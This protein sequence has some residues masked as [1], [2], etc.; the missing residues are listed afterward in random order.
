MTTAYHPQANG[1][2][3]WGHRQLQDSLCSWAAGVDWLA[4]LSWVL[5]GLR[6]AP[7]D[8]SGFSSAELVLGSPLTLPG[9]F[10]SSPEPLAAN[11]MQRIQRAPFP[12]PMC[13]LTYAEA[14]APPWQPSR[15]Q[16]LSTSAAAAPFKCYRHCTVA[17]TR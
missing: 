16:T 3:E 11:F 8:E 5:L 6:A 2:V 15:R 10:L 17:P 12:P 4:H 9:Q 1:M 13:P 7:K 14:A